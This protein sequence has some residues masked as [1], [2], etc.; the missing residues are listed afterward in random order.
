MNLTKLKTRAD[1]C[2]RCRKPMPQDRLDD[3]FLTCGCNSQ[4]D[5]PDRRHSLACIAGQRAEMSG[6]EKVKARKRRDAKTQHDRR[7]QR[8]HVKH[9][10]TGRK[11][12]TLKELALAKG[13]LCYACGEPVDLGLDGKH[14]DGPTLEHIVPRV[15]FR[16]G[17]GKVAKAWQRIFPAVPMPRGFSENHPVN[18]A[19]SHSHC[20]TNTR[21][22]EP[23]PNW[24]E[25]QK[26]RGT[27]PV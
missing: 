23:H 5:K 19:I 25:E 24:V 12:P 4:F 21:R 18:L 10:P 13:D 22:L 6:A 17:R 16:W 11:P 9:D 2:S 14:R 27:Y 15:K 3:G 1:R 20:N 7:V 26:W 8:N